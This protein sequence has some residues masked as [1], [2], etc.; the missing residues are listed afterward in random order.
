MLFEYL[1]FDSYQIAFGASLLKN[2]ARIIHTETKLRDRKH[3]IF[4]AFP[5][6]WIDITYSQTKELVLGSKMITL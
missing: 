3:G 2:Q 5:E 4:N 1:L 6:K